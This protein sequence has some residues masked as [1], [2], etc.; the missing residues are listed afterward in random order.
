MANTKLTAAVA[1]TTSLV[2]GLLATPGA[3]PAAGAITSRRDVSGSVESAALTWRPRLFARAEGARATA[4]RGVGS[5]ARDSYLPSARAQARTAFCGHSGTVVVFIKDHTDDFAVSNADADCSSRIKNIGV[6]LTV[7]KN[8][9]KINQLATSA[10]V[11]NSGLADAPARIYDCNNCAGDWL[12]GMN[13]VFKKYLNGQVIDPPDTGTCSLVVDG[14]ENPTG[15]VCFG[16]DDLF[17][18]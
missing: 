7:S 17:V 5:T 9:G 16:V 14:N 4:A 3:A 15:W 1:T 6:D 8:G 13:S 12:A 18:P 10:S 2:V 11:D